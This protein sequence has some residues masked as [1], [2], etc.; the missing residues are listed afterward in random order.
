[1]TEKQ[2]EQ[3]RINRPTYRGKEATG[4]HTESIYRQT[5][6]ENINNNIAE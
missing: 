6:L 5:E 2:D 3:G 4:G 1:M